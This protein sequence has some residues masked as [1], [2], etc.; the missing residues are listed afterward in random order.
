MITGQFG[1]L[2]IEL[3]KRL[4]LPDLQPDDKNTCLLRILGK[5]DV[6]LE[7]DKDSDYLLIGT[8][9]GEIAPGRFRE[10]LLE[11]AL[12]ANSLPSPLY[13]IFGFSKKNNH[14][15]MFERLWIKELSG[16]KLAQY[17][18]SFAQKAIVWKEAIQKDQIPLIGNF[19][20]SDHGSGMFGL[21]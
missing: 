20:T 10:D 18:D 15:I 6:Q 19:T 5:I 2:L 21:R 1:A 11:A 14:F 12:K 3:G 4:N 16:D 9:F 7:I 13:G 8:D 17:L